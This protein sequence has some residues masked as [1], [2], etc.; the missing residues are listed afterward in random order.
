MD[1]PIQKMISEVK[2]RYDLEAREFRGEATLMVPARNLV[3]FCR[4][5]RDQYG[6]EMLED[7]TAVDYWPEQAPRFHVVYHLYSFGHNVTLCLRVPLDGNA[8]SV[9]TLETVYPN[10]NWHEREI[11]DM[12]GIRFEGH[13]DP[14]RILMPQ[15]W[16]G[17]PQR[18][19]YPLGY[20]EV[21]F[22]FNFD[23][24]SLKKPAPRE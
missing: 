16:Q 19:D 9:D 24:I 8:P 2:D 12:F 4:Q 1:D 3:D 17:H 20:E 21:Q 5:L 13:S 23:Q 15:D 10:A 18:K 14:R 11:W 7:E 22:T 6:F